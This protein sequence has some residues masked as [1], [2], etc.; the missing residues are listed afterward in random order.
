MVSSSL[1]CYRKVSIINYN[2]TVYLWAILKLSKIP[3]ILQ[4]ENIEET[5]K[6]KQG[7]KLDKE[8][9]NEKVQKDIRNRD[10]RNWD[11]KKW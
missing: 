1:R 10:R 11:I 9:E 8:K 2:C 3:I 4:R 6:I 7:I 5:R